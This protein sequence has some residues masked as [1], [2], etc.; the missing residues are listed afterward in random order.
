MIHIEVKLNRKNQIH[1]YL[2]KGHAIKK[3]GTR[4]HLAVCSAL[5]IL[6]YQFFYSSKEFFESAIASQ[7]MEAGLFEI[8]MKKLN[9]FT[10]RLAHDFTLL[11]NYFLIGVNLLVK[12]YPAHIN[13]KLL[14]E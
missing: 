8:K 5:S 4:E 12:N 9:E 7:K 2:S 11:S 3:E 6:E 10:Q 13:L 1:R 14:K